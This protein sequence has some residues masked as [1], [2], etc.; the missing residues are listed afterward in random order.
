MQVTPTA[1][2][3]VPQGV[4]KTGSKMP[5]VE[6]ISYEHQ[7]NS[8]LDPSQP[9][10]GRRHGSFIW[11]VVSDIGKQKRKNS[12]PVEYAYIAD[13]SADTLTAQ[14]H[15]RKTCRDWTNCG[16]ERICRDTSFS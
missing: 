5:K 16:I 8:R 9:V 3:P 1:A 11:K 15:R 6:R 4:H 13:E 14:F 7:F 12:K 2:K 10:R